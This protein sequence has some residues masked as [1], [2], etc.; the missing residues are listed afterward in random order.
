MNAQEIESGLPAPLARALDA[1]AVSVANVRRLTGGAVHETWSVDVTIECDSAE[2]ELRPLVL[3]SFG[4]LGPQS[5]TARQE[6]TV[7]KAAADAG[8]PAPHPLVVLEDAFSLP[9]YLMQRLDGETI[10][11]R[12]VTQ[13]A[14][15]GARAVLTRQ[16]GETAAAIH[17]VPLT[18][19]LRAVLRSPD[20]G[21]SPA[22]FE[23]PRMEATYRAIVPNP[24]PA[25]ELG[26]RWLAQRLPGPAELRLVHGDYR[27]GNLIVGPEGLRAVLDWEGAHIGDPAED[28]GWACVRSW[29]FGAHHLPAG[30]AGTRDEL[31]SAYE[32]AA[33]APVDRERVRWWEV[34]GNL[35][36][37]VAILTIA[38]PFL[39]AL[40]HDVEPGAIGRRF[41]EIELETLDL[42]GGEG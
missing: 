26:L 1:R 25:F 19:E 4:T 20:A 28:L 2:P 31:F 36:W 33:G 42:I 22:A 17:R 7:L 41:A 8:V 27:V 5:M 40:T 6:Y 15:A 10:G 24:H 30:G 37:G 16:L 12:I 14:L 18:Q 39:K 21:E 23:L 11:R 32:A 38:D 3:R 9:C 29:R 35:R 34:F 13:P